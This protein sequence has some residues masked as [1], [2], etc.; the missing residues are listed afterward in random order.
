MEEE[1]PLRIGRDWIRFGTNQSQ[2]DNYY[3][4][5]PDAWCQVGDL[6]SV[7]MRTVISTPG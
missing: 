4:L 6:A 1:K 5:R 3:Q 2:L 7:V